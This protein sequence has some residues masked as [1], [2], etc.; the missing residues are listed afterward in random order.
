[1]DFLTL[2]L[3]E[4][5]NPRCCLMHSQ[6]PDCP[7]SFSCL[8]TVPDLIVSGC[9]DFQEA[10]A[11]VSTQSNGKNNQNKERKGNE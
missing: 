9:S 6:L 3:V 8:D 4:K 5:D 11:S 7:T 10:D 2:Q 1:M